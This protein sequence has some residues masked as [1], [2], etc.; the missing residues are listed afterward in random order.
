MNTFLA[1]TNNEIVDDNSNDRVTSVITATESFELD[2][3]FLRAPFAAD[4]AERPVRRGAMSTRLRRRRGARRCA[5]GRGLHRRPMPPHS[6]HA[7]TTA[8][9]L[10]L[11]YYVRPAR[12]GRSTRA[13]LTR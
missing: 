7:H 2:V 3:N 8:F 11:S 4:R 12:A 1:A 9:L 10:L 5:T 13:R 6:D